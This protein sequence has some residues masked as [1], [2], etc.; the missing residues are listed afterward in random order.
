MFKR[1]S[2]FF[3]VVL[4][5]VFFVG[6][7]KDTDENVDT[8]TERTYVADGVYTAFKWDTSSNA[9]QLTWVS[10]T[11]KDDKVV[12]YYIDTLQGKV[13]KDESGKATGANFNAKT[14]KELK[15][16]YGMHKPSSNTSTIE[17]YQE[18]LRTTTY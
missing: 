1:L 11:I 4:T 10:V 5:A 9:Q 7:D 17:E 12:S 18:Y 3:L 15:Y 14:K 13:T 16:E 8:P 6:C 2:L